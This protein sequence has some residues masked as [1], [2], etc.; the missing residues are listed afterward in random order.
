MKFT[1]CCTGCGCPVKTSEEDSEE[2]YATCRKCGARTEYHRE[3]DAAVIRLK[4]YASMFFF[5]VL[6]RYI[7][8]CPECGRR[9]ARSADGTDTTTRCTKCGAI[10]RHEITDNMAYIKIEEYS[11]K[12]PAVSRH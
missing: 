3:S 8:T 11:G 5:F 4:S 9:L 2:G 6:R 12:K 7:I 1:V 10:I